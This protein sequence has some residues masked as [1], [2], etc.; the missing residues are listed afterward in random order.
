M[1]AEDIPPSVVLNVDILPILTSGIFSSHSV[2]TV[3][4]GANLSPSVT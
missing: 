4:L 1:P 3:D 2:M